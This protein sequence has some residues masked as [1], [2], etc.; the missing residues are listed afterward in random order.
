MGYL[1]RHDRGIW[2]AVAS[3]TIAV[4]LFA[5]AADAARPVRATP[6]R[7]APCTGTDI[8]AE[9]QDPAAAARAIGCLI[10]AERAR[11]HLVAVVPEGHLGRA[12]ARHS[13]AMMRTGVFDHRVPGEA[14]L[15]ARV[16]ATGYL[17]HARRSRLAEALACGTDDEATPGALVAALLAS[18]PH[19]AILLDPGFRQYGIG[20][21]AG[22]PDPEASEIPGATLTLTFGQVVLR[23]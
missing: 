21:M 1:R 13:E 19:R 20:L 23:R 11:R 12:A 4:M 8:P 18:P 14:A 6:V 10:N 16:R 22:I 17:A 15:G 3:T 7:A 2:P 9:A 5:T